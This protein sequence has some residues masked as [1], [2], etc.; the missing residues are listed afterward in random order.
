ME[1]SRRTYHSVEFRDL[2][3]QPVFIQG[4]QRFASDHVHGTL[5]YL[6]V[7]G[8]H[9]QIERLANS[10]LGKERKA[11]VSFSAKPRALPRVKGGSIS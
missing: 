2:P 6:L 10:L 11:T 1:R 8:R 9:Q 5:V 3:Q 7:Q 4:V